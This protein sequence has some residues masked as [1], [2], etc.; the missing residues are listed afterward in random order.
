[1]W[2]QIFLSVE[3]PK[4]TDKKIGFEKVTHARF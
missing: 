1:L 4:P 3:R 2:R